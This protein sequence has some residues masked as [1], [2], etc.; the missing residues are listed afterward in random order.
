MEENFASKNLT[1]HKIHIPSKLP[2][3][4]RREICGPLWKNIINYIENKEVEEI[5]KIVKSIDKQKGVICL[6]HPFIEAVDTFP[7]KSLRQGMCNYIFFYDSSGQNQWIL[8]QCTS[9]VDAIFSPTYS[10][11][12]KLSTNENVI[13]NSIRQILKAEEKANLKQYEIKKIVY[14]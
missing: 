13:L 10:G 12:H 2:S 6:P 4:L 14:D 8:C 1:Y 3:S 7:A 9:F 5:L 11:K